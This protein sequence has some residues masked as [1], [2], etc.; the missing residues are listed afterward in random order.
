MIPEIGH[1]AL[2]LALLIAL[3]QGVLPIVGAARG[4]GPWMDLARPAA[5]A[6]AM[7]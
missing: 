3:L 1:F 6:Q 2:I 4:I 7:F 5:K